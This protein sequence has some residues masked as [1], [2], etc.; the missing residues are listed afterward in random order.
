MIATIIIIV[1][2]SALLAWVAP[3]HDYEMRNRK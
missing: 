2:A 1:L 3:V